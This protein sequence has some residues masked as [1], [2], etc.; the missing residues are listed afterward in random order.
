[1]KITTIIFDLDGTLLPMDTDA[2]DKTYFKLLSSHLAQYGYEPEDFTKAI[3]SGCKAMV[4]NDGNKTNE[5][6]FWDR[7]AE[8]YGDKARLDHKYFA[9]FYEAP[10][11]KIRP[12]T[13]FNPLVPPFV[14]SL[15]DKGYRLII[16][17]NPLFPARAIFKRIEWAGLDRDDF[18][19]V[20]TYENSY[21]AK[22]STDYYQDIVDQLKLDPSRCIMIGNNVD[23]DMVASKLGMKVY[24]I[25]DYLLNPHDKDINAY[26]HGTFSQMMD[27]VNNLD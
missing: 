26:P 18:E 16:A 4:N 27:F 15:K 24:L 9:E 13:S 8:I 2:Y 12:T 1:M 6:V 5:E 25:T 7:F 19:L 3:W 20:T 11:D 21:H 23:E 22:P 14:K 10:Y 17:T